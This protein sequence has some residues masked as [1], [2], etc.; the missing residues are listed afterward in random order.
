MTLLPIT[1][2][3]EPRHWASGRARDI[4]YVVVHCTDGHEGANDAENG[5]AYDKRRSDSTSCHIMVD[6]NS[7]LREVRDVDT[8]YAAYPKGNALGIQ[9]ELCHSGAWDLSEPNDAATFDNGAQVVAQL[10]LA[11]NLPAVHLTVAQVRTAWYA[12]PGSRPRGLA[13]HWD[14][15]RAYPEDGG[16]HTDPGSTFPWG[17]FTKRVQGYMLPTTEE[18]DMDKAQINQLE[19]CWHL[20]LAMAAGQDTAQVHDHDGVMSLTGLYERVAASVTVSDA[21]I[22]S[23]AAAVAKL[24]AGQALT[25]EDVT[26]G[27]RAAFAHGLGGE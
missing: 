4:Q 13:G 15:T 14:V 26:T 21:Q 25:V 24:P 1:W 7:A 22:E 11:H 6:T 10:C 20:L 27:V 2:A 8:A 16:S 23:L 19:D 12:A 18:N 3:G 17:E 9:V 5:I